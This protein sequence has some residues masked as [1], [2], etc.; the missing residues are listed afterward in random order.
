MQASR[1]QSLTYSKAETV[2]CK[3]IAKSFFEPIVIEIKRVQCKYHL[4]TQNI[5]CYYF[6]S[7][8]E[9]DNYHLINR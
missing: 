5:L 4:H 6:C 1:I 3:R 9:K 2:Q 7:N 8:S